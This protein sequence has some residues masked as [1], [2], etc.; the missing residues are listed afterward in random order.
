[1]ENPWP[2]FNAVMNGTSATL[3]MLGYWFIRR[4]NV[5]KHLLCM[6]S[7]LGTSTIF[8]IS[9]LIYHYQVGSVR[10]TGTGTIRTVYFTIL[11]THTVLAVAIV[12]MILRAVFLAMK[13]RFAEHRKLARWTL[14]LW[15]Y[16]SITG[17]VIYGMLY[18]G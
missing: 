4:G 10:Y 6:A 5:Q 8:L 14:P 9:Y 1:M 11:L 3:L 13:G 12:P 7:A 17:V 2:A 16:V 18:H 15:L